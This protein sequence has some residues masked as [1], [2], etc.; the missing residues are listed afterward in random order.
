MDS[1][2]IFD[3]IYLILPMLVV[4]VGALTV[5]MVDAFCE[6]DRQY[7]LA[8]RSGSSWNA[9]FFTTAILLL[10]LG[11]LGYV[12]PS[13]HSA[14]VV[15][16]S[17]LVNFSQ[18]LTIFSGTLFVDPYT[19]LISALL[20][21]TATLCMLVGK[22]Y[23]VGEGVSRVGEY[24]TLYLMSTF[25]A[26]L[27]VA[28]ADLIALFIGLEILSMALYCMCGAA[29]FRAS[30]AESAMKYFFL[31]SFS[32]AFFL[33]GMALLYGVTGSFSLV[34]LAE[35]MSEYSDVAHSSG[36]VTLGIMLLLV[37]L[38]FKIGAV[39]LHFWAPDVYQGAPTPVT[40]YM[41]SVV[42]ISSVA[43]AL[44][45]LWFSFGSTE[46]YELWAYA[47]W[48]AALLTMIVGNVIA[49]RQQSVKR[50]LAYSSIAHAGYMLMGFLAGPQEGGLSAILFYLIAY[51]VMTI[52]AFGVVM[53]V[54]SKNPQD[55]NGDHI[56]NFKGLGKR[57]PFLAV[58]MALFLLSLAGLPPGLSGLLGKFFLF[59][60]VI[61]ADYTGLAIVGVLCSAVS[62]YYY[63]RVI[64]AM[65]F[66]SSSEVANIEDSNE[67]K[68]IENTRAILL[69]TPLSATLA[70]CAL[71]TVVIGVV[72]SFFYELVQGVL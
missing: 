46:L 59:S 22:D 16:A 38:L 1:S 3:H 27:F 34:S 42:K 36:V 53:A 41:A 66:D 14:T 45:I 2:L 54:A 55:I 25:G 6:S 63:L 28:A 48:L 72:P 68:S 12:A 37:G 50:M 64:V 17:S 29:L 57:K 32:S 10:A 43:V 47:I 58:V 7:E 71:L 62:C 15:D 51:A 13:Y 69:S 24:S 56:D 60:A 67:A 61:R 44:R 23:L 20:L 21:A 18:P 52:G 33:F 35:Y 31:G 39:P 5:M 70:F 8:S 19:F 9:G 11:M 30:S 40:I 4:A 49:L 26:L 65:Y